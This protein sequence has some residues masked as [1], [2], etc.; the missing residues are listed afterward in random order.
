MPFST[1]VTTEIEAG[2]PTTQDLFSKIKTNEDDHET[3]IVSLEAGSATTYP[4]YEFYVSGPYEGYTPLLGCGHIR[5]AFNITV[6]AGRLA[7]IKAGTSGT[8]QIDFKYKRGAG[9]WTSIFSTLPSVASTSGDYA[10]STNGILSVTSLLA[11]DLVRMDITTTQ[12]GT[13]NSIIGLL[14]FEKV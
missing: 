9:S 8:T 12:A 4:P 14:E 7:I 10:V 13:P 3:R 1:I 11:G 2:D 6:L 5:I